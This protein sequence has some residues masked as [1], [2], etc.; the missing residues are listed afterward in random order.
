[1]VKAFF[2]SVPIP[3]P[4]GSYPF[5]IVDSGLPYASPAARKERP[6]EVELG[7]GYFSLLRE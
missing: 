5:L 2:S 3:C 4:S 6:I 7:A 1:M